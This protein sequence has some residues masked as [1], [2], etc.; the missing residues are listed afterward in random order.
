MEVST[1]WFGLTAAASLSTSKSLEVERAVT[2]TESP[3]A[4][5]GLD[6]ESGGSGAAAPPPGF[7]G[8][9]NIQSSY[10]AVCAGGSI[11]GSSQK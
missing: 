10:I 1:I 2:L 8:H 6:F 5:P 3:D 11:P 4:T 9:P 7:Q